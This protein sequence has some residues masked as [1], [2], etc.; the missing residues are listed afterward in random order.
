M[1]I[2][3]NR[4]V[5]DID[6]SLQTDNGDINRYPFDKYELRA[7]YGLYDAGD[8]DTNITFGAVAYGELQNWR[9]KMDFYQEA[10]KIYLDIVM[11]R[12]PS[13]R[14]FSTFVVILMWMVTISVVCITFH[15]V[16]RRKEVVS[17]FFFLG[18]DNLDTATFGRNGNTF[19][20]TSCHKEYSAQCSSYW[21]S[22]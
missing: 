22:L 8:T 13:T 1:T 9:L 10:D 16:I 19:I 6:Y 3:A 21:N 20:C 4:S 11:K 12:S 18:V 15:F 5:F 2:P 7:D 17:R 14:I